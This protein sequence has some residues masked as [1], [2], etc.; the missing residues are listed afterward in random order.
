MLAKC[1]P[2]YFQEPTATSASNASQCLSQQS[3]DPLYLQHYLFPISI[4]APQPFQLSNA[5]KASAVRLALAQESI[6]VDPFGHH[7][8]SS[9]TSLQSPHVLEFNDIVQSSISNTEKADWVDEGASDDEDYCESSL[10][11]VNERMNL[12]MERGMCEGIEDS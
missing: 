3:I 1:L 9:S 5:P 10:L 6:L 2:R 12:E 7:F 11:K 4:A 8:T